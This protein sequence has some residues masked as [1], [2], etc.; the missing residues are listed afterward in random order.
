MPVPADRE[1]VP[2]RLLRTSALAEI[3]RAI[4]DGTL[5]P[6]E[7]LRDA[8]LC[9]WLGL[10]RTPV[11]EALARLEEDGLVETSPPRFTRVTPLDRRAARDAFEVVASLHALAAERAVPRCGADE[12]D[13]M[14]AANERFAAALRA[15]DVDAAIDADDAF[16]DVFVLASANEEIAR[17]LERLMPRLRRVERLRFASLTGR[18]S[19]AQHE[20]IIQTAQAADARAAA[21]ALRDNWL[22]LGALIDASLPDEET[23]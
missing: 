13:A 22:T 12:L 8:E 18:R 7:R 19:V 1:P 16:H 23:P 10:S 17:T 20:R 21:A 4:M 3:R 11:R 9:A 2:R 6:G 15:G 14:R 5:S